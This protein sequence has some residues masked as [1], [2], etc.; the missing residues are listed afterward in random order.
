MLLKTIQLGFSKITDWLLVRSYKLHE[1]L[2]IGY[3]GG[4]DGPGWI[5]S[6]ARPESFRPSCT[7]RL[8]VQLA[9]QY[10]ADSFLYPGI[11]EYEYK[12]QN[13]IIILFT[14]KFFMINIIF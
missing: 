14:L 10:F 8:G 12:F 6:V 1:I 3:R 9:G 13:L 2:F 7:D 5:G 4:R 11:Y